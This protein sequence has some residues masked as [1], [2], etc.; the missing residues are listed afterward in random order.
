[1]FCHAPR[2]IRI[3]LQV[4]KMNRVRPSQVHWSSSMALASPL[5]SSSSSSVSRSTTRILSESAA[6]SSRTRWET[7]TWPSPAWYSS[8]SCCIQSATTCSCPRTSCSPGRGRQNYNETL[9]KAQRTRGLSSYH[10]YK[11]KFWSNFIFRIS[12]KHQLQN[13]NLTSASP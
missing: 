6:Q 5:F 10:K 9:P 2:L 12:T 3:Q 11:H 1:M 4:V 8:P 13:L 7:W